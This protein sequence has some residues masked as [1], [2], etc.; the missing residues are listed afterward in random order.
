MNRI[1]CGLS[2]LFAL[3]VAFHGVQGS[4]RIEKNLKFLSS[5]STFQ[6]KT[7]QHV[8]EMNLVNL[9]YGVVST[10]LDF[11]MTVNQEGLMT[12]NA[13]LYKTSSDFYVHLIVS[14]DNGDGK[15]ANVFLNKT[16]EVCKFL[17]TPSYETLIQL[18]YKELMKHENNIPASCP[19]TENVSIH[20]PT[21]F[22]LKLKLEKR[23]RLTSLYEMWR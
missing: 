1:I 5:H 14:F 17:S 11:N 6:P 15:F 22:A 20:F 21:R 9:T 4:V 16:V 18:Y 8:Y 2:L 10:D 7:F 13:F 19:F 23:F 3:L 12:M